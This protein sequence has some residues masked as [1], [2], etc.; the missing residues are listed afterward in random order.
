MVLI[1]LSVILVKLHSFPNQEQV[2]YD[3]FFAHTEQNRFSSELKGV[4]YAHSN[5][6]EDGVVYLEVDLLSLYTPV[7]EGG[8]HQLRSVHING[9][10]AVFEVGTR[11][12]CLNGQFATMSAP[13]IL[14]NSR[15]CVPLDFFSDCLEGIEL[16]TDEEN[17]R[18]ILLQTGTIALALKEQA[19]ADPI[20]YTE[21]YKQTSPASIMD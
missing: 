6:S 10:L 16:R 12:V 4:R 11:S 15:L 9:E 14:R 5:L 1:F 8:N 2:L 21:R 13:S 19:P 7:S 17:E 18:K 3:V 20:V